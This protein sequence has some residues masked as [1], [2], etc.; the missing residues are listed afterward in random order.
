M[1]EKMKSKGIKPNTYTYGHIINGYVEMGKMEESMSWFVS[2]VNDGIHPD[3]VTCTTMIKG[4]A[5]KKDIE[6]TKKI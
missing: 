6:N 2:M 1:I 3:V 4:Y 5:A